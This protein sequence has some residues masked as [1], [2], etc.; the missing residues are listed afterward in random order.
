MSTEDNK[1]VSLTKK[2]FS[3]FLF[4]LVS[5]RWQEIVL[6]SGLYGG[7]VFVML[8]IGRM[9]EPGGGMND[10]SAFF[11]TA[12]VVAFAVVLNMLVYG[13]LRSVV[14]VGCEPLDP[15][16]LLK[17][18]RQFFWR[19][20]RVEILLTLFTMLFFVLFSLFIGSVLQIEKEDTL[21][22]LR[23][24]GISMFLS[25]MSL[26]KF[27]LV[28]GGVVFVRGSSVREAFGCL[29]QC[30]LGDGGKVLGVYAVSVVVV[31]IVSYLL[32]L[33]TEFGKDTLVISLLN[34][35]VVGVSVVLWGLCSL[36]FV[37]RFAAR[38][39]EQVNS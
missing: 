32:Q 3:G 29:R 4:S 22:Q 34:G 13:F 37:G 8:E 1:F 10:G 18:G 15:V 30:R 9:M 19:M 38:S 17:I 23:V 28:V 24:G 25:L 21:G 7:L 39:G 14:V 26:M 27:R 36:W 35:A 20:F 33:A 31:S 6:L 12:G 2:P 16:V 5:G 11:V